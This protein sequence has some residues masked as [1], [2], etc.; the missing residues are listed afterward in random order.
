M[1]G[2]MARILVVAAV[3]L[4]L[5]GCSGGDAPVAKPA[6]PQ[7]TAAAAPTASGTGGTVV[8]AP[9]KFV[10]VVEASGRTNERF[11]L[12]KGALKASIGE[13]TDEAIIKAIF[14]CDGRAIEVP[15]GKPVQATDSEKIRLFEAIDKVPA[16]GVADPTSALDLAFAHDPELVYLIVAG[17]VDEKVGETL[18]RLNSKGSTVVHIVA[19]FDDSGKEALQKIATKNGGQYK[20]FSEADCREVIRKHGGGR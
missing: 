12:I 1:T 14:F 3:T 11:D 4:T 7:G 20:F 18:R 8:Y 17:P 6:A 19:F 13:T 2:K 16:S 15:E 5:A 10:F 9:R